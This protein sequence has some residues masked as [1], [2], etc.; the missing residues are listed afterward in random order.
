MLAPVTEVHYGEERLLRLNLASHALVPAFVEQLESDAGRSVDYRRCGTLL[1]ARDNDDNA[2][3]HELFAFQQRLGLEVRR[4]RSGELRSQEPA[5]A[6]SVRG[7]ILVEGD[8][9]I[10]NRAL[11]EALLI[12]CERRGVRVVKARVAEVLVDG[13]AVSGLRLDDDAAVQAANVVV[14]AG[15]G[16]GGI[17]GVG[18]FPIRPV[19]GQLLHLQARDRAPLLS[20]NVRGLDVYL[21]PRTDGRLVI[22]AT[23]E[24]QGF[25][26]S[27]TAG[28]VRDLLEAAYELVPG[29]TELELVEVAVGHRPASPDNAPLIGRGDVQGSFVATGHF[30]N[31]ILLLPVTS[32]AVEALLT[33]TEAPEEIAGFEPGR[34]AA[35][36]SS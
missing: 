10:D 9:Q 31:G 26:T 18:T 28:A 8:H 33:G 6:P 3:L 1:V 16:S 13:G 2:A 35:V 11:V 36:G 19:K 25:D 4:L 7:G 27:V 30:R 23:V 15:A 17:T 24:E 34:F 29:I 22:G 21:V 32:I 12:A 5:L 20:H 14:A